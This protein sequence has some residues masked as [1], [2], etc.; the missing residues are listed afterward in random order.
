MSLLREGP[1]TNTNPTQK[2]IL[3]PPLFSA[4]A[5]QTAGMPHSSAELTKRQ[6]RAIHD[7]LW[8]AGHYLAKLR[9]RTDELHYSSTRHLCGG[10]NVDE[11][12]IFT[13]D[14]RPA[15]DVR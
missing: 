2:R 8:P 15:P 10:N 11:S 9:A 13:E 12:L 6:A 14:R 7:A 3:F 5:R 4:S 1:R